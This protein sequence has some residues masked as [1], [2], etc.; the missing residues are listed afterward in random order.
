MLSKI[1]EDVDQAVADL[2]WRRQRAG[3]IPVAPHVSV[4]QPGAI[5][6]AG[7]ATGEAVDAGAQAVG[8]VSLD[9]EMNVIGLNGEMHDAKVFAAGGGECQR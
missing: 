7:H 9:D 3:V 8:G 4:P 5:E 6:R 2:P 1:E